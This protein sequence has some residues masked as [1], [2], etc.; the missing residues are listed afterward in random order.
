MHDPSS[1]SANR[2]RGLWGALVAFGR[3]FDLGRRILINLV[4]LFLLL[5]VISALSTDTQPSLPSKAALVVQPK[6]I[7]VEQLSGDPTARAI[8][9]L[10]DSGPSE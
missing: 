8:E 9:A 10:M 7:L 2:P 5:L 3:A 4:F 6:G 1:S